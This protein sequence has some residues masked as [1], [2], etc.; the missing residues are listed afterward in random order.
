MPIREYECKD[1][2][3]KFETIE[4]GTDSEKPSCPRCHSENVEKKLSLFSGSSAM[5]ASCKIT[6][7]FG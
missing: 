2:Q 7:G 4:L 5:G 1:C 3:L 6:R